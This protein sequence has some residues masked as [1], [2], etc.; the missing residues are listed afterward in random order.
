[1]VASHH[2]FNLSKLQLRGYIYISLTEIPYILLYSIYWTGIYGI[3]FPRADV[4]MLRIDLIIINVEFCWLFNFM[5]FSPAKKTIFTLKSDSFFA[6]G[7]FKSIIMGFQKG[8]CPFP[9]NGDG[10]RFRQ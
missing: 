5:C 4:G 6:R 8:P 10:T 9:V 1:M 3:F 2:F 7:C